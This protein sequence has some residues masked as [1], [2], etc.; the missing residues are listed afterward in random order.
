MRLDA[1]RDEKPIGRCFASGRYRVLLGADDEVGAWVCAQLLYPEHWT[2]GMGVAIGI[3]RAQSLVAGATY[4]Q[5]NSVNVWVG[6]A[7]SEPGWINRATLR[8]LFDYPFGQL[9]AKRVSAL[10]DAS[11]TRS[12]RFAE[13]LGFSVEATLEASAP[14]GGDQIVYRMRAKDCRWLQLK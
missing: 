10:V 7:S 13:R 11:N 1:S 5:F 14:D 3:T 2:P 12:R 9:K 6:I 4:F 8:F